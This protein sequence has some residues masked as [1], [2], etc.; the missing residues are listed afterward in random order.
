MLNKAKEIQAQLIDW[1]R[2]F[3][4][5]PELGF[6]EKR[7]STKLAGILEQMGCRV[8][9][10]VGKT[11]VIAELGSGSPVVAIRA[12]ID[13]LPIL[14]DN[15]VDYAS[16]NRGVMHACGHDAHASMAL[17]AAAL[18][19]NETFPG[20]VRLLFQP[21][22]EV[23]DD[24]GISGA[25]RMI[26]D[27]A[28]KDVDFIIAAHV[29][30]HIPTGAIAIESGPASGG[31]DSWFGKI[32]GK[33]GHGARPQETVDTFYL[34]AHV[35]LA[36]NAIVS[37]RLDPFDPAVISIGSINGGHTENVI[38]DEIRITGTLRFTRAQ[39]QKKIHSEIK[40]AFEIARTLGGSYD[41]KFEIGT[42]PMYNDPLV[43]DMIADAG[44]EL[45]G[46]KNVL[47]FIKGLGAE[48]FGCFSEIA[49]GAMFSLGVHIKDDPRI[50]HHRLFDIN[51]SALPIGTAIITETALRLLHSRRS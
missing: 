48:D 51:E 29:D 4:Q 42:P 23:A 17:G 38:P 6:K 5:H 27:G 3:H 14:E 8:R 41:L 11:G 44:R 1:R 2:D 45:L 35:M 36:L 7:T 10:E 30:P 24:E 32:I 50:I 22:E 33:G 18:L 12:D 31:V 39:V 9:R 40:R 13:A 46:K 37:R 25:P 26:E 47:P 16:V 34:A 20:T 19:K 21:A 15:H 43:S 28:M 49:P